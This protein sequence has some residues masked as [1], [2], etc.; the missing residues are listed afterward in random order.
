MKKIIEGIVFS[1]DIKRI[2]NGINAYDFKY[3]GIPS[4]YVISDVRR[5]FKKDVSKIF[6]NKV[7]IISED[8]MMDINKLIVGDYPH[9][10]AR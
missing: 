6:N 2:F 1:E 10:I 9:C 7:S 3:D 5:D 4:N 8:E